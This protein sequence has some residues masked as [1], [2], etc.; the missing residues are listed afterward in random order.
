MADADQLEI[1]DSM[2]REVVERL[3]TWAHDADEIE[4]HESA[5][6]AI[7]GLSGSEAEAFTAGLPAVR[8]WADSI[9]NK[10]HH[11]GVKMLGSTLLRD[12]KATNRHAAR[13][14]VYELVAEDWTDTTPGENLATWGDTETGYSVEG[15]GGLIF[16]RKASGKTLLAER[17]VG[18]YLGLAGFETLLGYPVEPIPEGAIWVFF[19]LDGLPEIRASMARLT[20]SNG[21]PF[22][23]AVGDRLK[24]V[25]NFPGQGGKDPR[26][27]AEAI[28]RLE[29]NGGRQVAGVT[30]DN[31]LGAYDDVSSPNRASF[32]A[33]SIAAAAGEA[34]AEARRFDVI[35]QALKGTRPA[36][37]ADAMFSEAGLNAMGGIVSLYSLG[38][39]ARDGSKPTRIELRHHKGAGHNSKAAR[40]F[41]VDLPSGRVHWADEA[42]SEKHQGWLDALTFER[43]TLSDAAASWEIELGATEARS[44]TLKS[45]GYI[46]Q[47]GD[48][49]GPAIVWEKLV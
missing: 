47:T 34:I 2:R 22:L 42:P 21:T 46:G 45:R 17:K 13:G 38:E 29:D 12:Y 18:G 10:E 37:E 41:L 23:V 8:R 11:D 1:T 40:V 9:L 33:N 25:R 48:R 27:L 5:T 14:A 6:R 32:A 3:Q 36:S 16:G 20:T 49:R 43:F 31:L 7:F 44:R 15:R 4:V 19:A 39:G 30:I 24:V 35:T 26:A 28:E